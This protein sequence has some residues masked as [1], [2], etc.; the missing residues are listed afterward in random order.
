MKRFRTL[1]PYIIGISLFLITNWAYAATFIVDNL[2]D[3]DD[4]NPYTEGDGTNTLRKCIRLANETPGADTIN[5]GVSGTISPASALPEIYDDGTVIDAS[6]QWIGIWPSGQPGIT[7]DGSGAGDANGLVIDA[8]NCHIR[9]LF[10]T[11]FQGTGVVIRRGAQFN[12]VGGTGVGHR[13]VISGNAQRGVYL[14]NSGTDNNVIAGNYIGTDVNGTADLGN[15]EDGVCIESGAQSNTIGG[16]TDGERNIISGN[17]YGV[18]ILHTGTD[19]NVVSGN[20]IGTDVSGTADLGNTYTGVHIEYGAHSNTIGGTTDGERNIISGT[21]LY[22]GVAIAGLGTNNNVVSG[23][24]IGT[25]VTGTKNLGNRRNGATI[26]SEAQFNTIGGTTAGERNIIAGNNQDGVMISDTGTDNNVVSGNYIGTDVSGTVALRN[27]GNGIVISEGA[28]SNT[29]GGTT[30]GERNIISGNGMRGVEI[31][32]IGTDNNVISGNYIG[33]DVTGTVDLGNSDR[34]VMIEG[35]AQSNII[36]GTTDGE[37]NII[38]GNNA[39]G[40]YIQHSGTDNNKVSGNYI[41]TDVSGTSDLGN[42]WKGVVIDGGAQSNTI[43]GTTDGERNIISGNDFG[44]HIQHSGTNNNIISGNYIGT[45]V[46]GTAGIG[47]ARV[48]VAISDGAQ[49]NIIGGTGSG[50]GNTIVFNDGNGVEVGDTGT[51]DYNRISGNS[52][53]D[54][55]GLGIELVNGGNDEIPAPTITSNNLVGDTLIVSGNGAGAN[56]TVEIFEADSFESGEGM[57]YLGSLDADGDG[58]FS[59]LIDVTGKGLSVGDPL[60]AT[61]THTNNNTS[62]FS[63]PPVPVELPTTLQVIAVYPEPGDTAKCETTIYATFSKPVD[64]STLTSSTIRVEGTQSGVVN[65]SIT[66]EPDISRVIFTPDVLFASNERITVTLT[67]DIKDTDGNGL[68]GDRDGTSEGSPED[69]F[70]W[71]FSTMPHALSLDGDEDYVDISTTPVAQDKR[72]VEAWFKVRD[73]TISTRKQVVY[74]EGGGGRG[75]NIYVFDGLLYVGGWNKPEGESNWLG[76]Y[77]STNAIESNEWHHVALVLDGTETVQ[78]NALKAYLDGNQFGSGDGSQLWDHM[79]CV[80][81]AMIDETC[82]HDECRYEGSGHYFEGFIDEVRVWNIVRTQADI[83]TTMN[84]T[85]KGDEP[86]LVGYWNF[87]DSTAKDSSP[88]GNHGTLMGDA[89]IIPL[90]GTWPPK[91]IGDVSGNGTISAYDAALI[92]QYVVGLISEFPADSMGSPSAISPRSY[93]VRIPEISAKAGDRIYVPIAI[94]DA[95]GLFAGGISLKYDRTV[96]RAIKALPDMALNGSYWKANTELD[97]EVRFAFATTEAAT[98][99]VVTTVGQGNL[100]MVEFEVLPNAEG[101]TS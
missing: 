52:I 57:I 62:E 48:G 67:G 44:V 82:F 27:S 77:L 26:N 70:R 91:K 98:T 49:S 89:D 6:S 81:G 7:L 86:G 38:S 54:N 4:G 94:D 95:T 88:Y 75:L 69:D 59:G 34:G 22:D 21:D 47:N 83:R 45:D 23:N 72:T 43:G 46:N 56:A 93:I 15:S 24:Y 16:T 60:V 76:T 74:E 87:D 17:D 9:G 68:D 53:H 101:K 66:Y 37:R 42:S 29:I 40:V 31:R 51:E 50:E 10:I 14:C 64:E 97:G 28:Q 61:T 55:A 35:G 71:E 1:L 13:N 99:E 96:L 73:K 92:L 36:G 39:D 84:T 58:N 8:D 18:R 3:V 30:A 20:Y 78:P 11:K 32:N 2:G 79:A 80:I 90:V 19:N 85:L 25:D 63:A 5:F 65:G 41:G 100:L 33:T 12:T